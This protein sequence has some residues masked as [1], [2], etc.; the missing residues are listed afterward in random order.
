MQCLQPARCFSPAHTPLA[1]RF[2]LVQEET[3]LQ[4]QVSAL[5]PALPHWQNQGKRQF[6]QELFP[7]ESFLGL[8]CPG[9]WCGSGHTV[10]G[11][12]SPA[13]AVMQTPLT[14]SG[15]VAQVHRSS[16]IYKENVYF[17]HKKHTDYIQY[18]PTEVKKK[19]CI[20]HLLLQIHSTKDTAF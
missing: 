6:L 1:L 8:N 17:H 16:G 4:V 20:M 13:I 18:T 3:S 7:P 2:L 11:Q 15:K 19:K 5:G 9:F 12:E 10:G 14:T